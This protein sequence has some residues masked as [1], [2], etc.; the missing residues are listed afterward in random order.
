MTAVTAVNLTT[1]HPRSATRP[2]SRF[3]E[4]VVFLY[5]VITAAA[6]YLYGRF[7]APLLL[8]ALIVLLVRGERVPRVAIGWIMLLGTL[9]LF[10]FIFGLLHGNPGAWVMTS[11]F[12][13]EPVFLGAMF[14][15][16][17]GERRDLGALARTLDAAL[18]AVAI[19]GILVYVTKGSGGV[20]PDWLVDPDY[21]AAVYNEN[22]L[23]TNYQG[24]NSLVFLAPYALV[25]ALVSSRAELGTL[26]RLVL[27]GAALSG[28]I[29]SGRRIL[30]L[31]VPITVLSVVLADVTTRPRPGTKRKT[32]QTLIALVVG[33]TIVAGTLRAL[34]INVVSGLASSVS[35]SVLGSTSDIRILES[36]IILR[37]WSSSPIVGHGAGAV[38]TGFVRDPE[39]PWSFE[40][41]YHFILLDTGLLGFTIL[42]IWAIWVGSR[43]YIG[44]RNHLPIAAAILAG[45]IGSILASTVDP[46]L[47]KLD[48][49]WMAFVPFGVAVGVPAAYNDLAGV[50]A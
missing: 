23:R 43:L 12:I 9:G 15:I 49:M 30:L 16:L 42:A 39:A 7:L 1:R 11:V 34:G 8:I 13:Y 28:T 32:A 18:V 5:V 41:S 29:L 37:E 38:I 17:Y 24:Y 31:L 3:V 21:S 26:S 2:P 22:Q 20:L 36:Q 46:Y 10:S 14:A 6:P 19:L 35:N 40:L 45:F 47:L 44:T 4:V 48:G 50:E 27:V 33:A 25:R